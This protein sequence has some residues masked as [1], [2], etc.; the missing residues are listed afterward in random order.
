MFVCL[1]LYRDEPT[2]DRV[3]V[4]EFGDSYE[5]TLTIIIVYGIGGGLFV[6]FFII[7]MCYLRKQTLKHTRALKSHPKKTLRDDLTMRDL[8]ILLYRTETATLVSMIGESIDIMSDVWLAATL[9]TSNSDYNTSP[10]EHN[11]DLFYIGISSLLFALFGII[12]FGVKTYLL[13]S[14]YVVLQ[15]QSV[16]HELY[17]SADAPPTKLVLDNNNNKRS[18]KHG[19]DEH[20]PNG[21][22]GGE[23]FVYDKKHILR[24]VL[25]WDIFTGAME[26]IPQTLIALT[27]MI[28]WDE[29]SAS[30][31]ISVFTSVFLIVWKIVRLCMNCSG[32]G[33]GDQLSKDAVYDA[34]RQERQQIEFAKRNSGVAGV[35]GVAAVGPGGVGVAGAPQYGARQNVGEEAKYIQQPH[36]VYQQ[37]GQLPSASYSPH[38]WS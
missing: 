33:T 24:D 4:L 13:Q 20:T 2:F 10:R 3:S 23:E 31:I 35:A 27:V 6:I 26:D 32:C 5:Q 15:H 25:M 30:A 16:W 36:V 7:S 28:V 21:G 14:I 9:V 22:G 17:P 12:C 37:H 34:V 38:V 19:D 1:F 29:V 11:E 8:S 18:R